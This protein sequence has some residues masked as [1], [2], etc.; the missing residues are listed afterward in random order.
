MPT[1]S[2]DPRAGGI[3]RLER[4]VVL[5]LLSEDDGERSWSRLELGEGMGVT[6][7]EL[8]LALD[9]L[10]GAGVLQQDRG[11]VWPTPATRRLDALELI[12]I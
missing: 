5:V 8:A 1:E 4:A 9:G 2:S 6:E 11:R 12:G 10:L 3:R 7:D